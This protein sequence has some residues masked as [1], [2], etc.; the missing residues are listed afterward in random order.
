MVAQAHGSITL[1]S[2]RHIRALVQVFMLRSGLEKGSP[3]LIGLEK[4]LSFQFL[5]IE[6][7]QYVSCPSTTSNFRRPQNIELHGKLA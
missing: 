2:F 1:C 5:L 4:L 6:E 3:S 7:F